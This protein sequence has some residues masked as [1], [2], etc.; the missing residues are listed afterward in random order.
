[1]F[2]RSDFRCGGSGPTAAVGGTRR[3]GVLIGPV[4]SIR[5]GDW[6][7]VLAEALLHL[8]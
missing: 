1:M 6:Y 8:L 3:P 2:F 4:G 7:L 5:G